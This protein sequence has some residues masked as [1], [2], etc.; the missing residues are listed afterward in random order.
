MT[1]FAGDTKR[2]YGS[3][4]SG[5]DSNAPVAADYLES[6]LELAIGS[7]KTAHWSPNCTSV[8][9]GTEYCT[10]GTSKEYWPDAGTAYMDT[11]YV[12]PP[13]A[14]LGEPASPDDIAY[15]TGYASIY[16]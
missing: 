3:K 7:N 10:A 9:N 14:M 4:S 16:Y 11:S 2:W 8:D 6:A 13:S 5:D 1:T 15:T 12:A